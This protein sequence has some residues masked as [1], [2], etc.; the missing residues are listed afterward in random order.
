MQPHAQGTAP[1]RVAIDD[2][3]TRA[4]EYRGARVRGRPIQR[5]DPAKAAYA[6]AQSQQQ[7]LYGAPTRFA[8]LSASRRHGKPP[9]ELLL[10]L[11]PAPEFMNR[12][13]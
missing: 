11:G 13:H 2:L 8:P 9:A 12:S 6:D 5:S 4:L 1:E 7:R 3:Q 10:V